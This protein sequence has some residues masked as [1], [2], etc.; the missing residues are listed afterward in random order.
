MTRSIMKAETMKRWGFGKQ[1][2]D[3]VVREK[4]AAYGEKGGV[5][6]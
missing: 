6:W 3:K 1:K 5:K 4:L 2:T